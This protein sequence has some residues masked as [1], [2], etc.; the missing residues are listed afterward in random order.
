[1]TDVHILVTGANGQLGLTFKDAERPANET[2]V[3]VDK[4]ALDITNK[5][6]LQ[7][8]FAKHNFQYCINCAAYTNVEQ[9]ETNRDDAFLINADGVKYLA[10]VCGEF[11]TTLIHISTDYVFDGNKTSPYVESDST[12][13]INVYG[14]SKLLGEDYLKETLANYFIIRTSWLYSKF[15][16]NF[17]KTIAK[18]IEEQAD[19][20]ITTAEVGT[21]TSCVDLADFVLHI[22]R[23]ENTSYGTY[24]F[25]NEGKATWY[26]FGVEI[27][28][29]YIDYNIEK[30]TPVAAFKT[31]AQRPKYSVMDKS[32]I[33][34][35]FRRDW[36]VSLK[37]V[38]TT[39]E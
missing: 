32:K 17:L 39:L 9:A 19:L 7:S 15:G 12:E 14:A 25:S 11:N 23:T 4:E 1:M 28:K 6:A 31:Q 34:N 5:I 36:K 20:K 21:P 26:D 16:K 22:I 27:A 2:Y 30:I 24:H 3:F 29:G 10:E 38:I 37:R 35:A 18:K 8:F 13:P 33:P